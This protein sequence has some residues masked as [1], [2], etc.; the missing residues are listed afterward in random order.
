MGEWIVKKKKGS[1]FKKKKEKNHD[2]RGIEGISKFI[3]F[4]VM[5]LF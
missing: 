3:K 2:S 4:S 1:C 5:E